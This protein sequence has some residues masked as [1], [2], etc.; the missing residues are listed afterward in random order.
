MRQ[1][2][3]HPS[4]QTQVPHFARK[5]IKVGANSGA[6]SATPWEPYQDSIDI[7]RWAPQCNASSLPG[8]AAL[9][10]VGS[11]SN[12]GSPV[13]R[14]SPCLLPFLQGKP[15]ACLN[16][17]AIPP[18]RSRGKPRP[19]CSGRPGSSPPGCWRR[20]C[21]APPTPEVVVTY[22]HN[23]FH[24]PTLHV[25]HSAGG[26]HASRTVGRAS[27]RRTLPV[28]VQGRTPLQP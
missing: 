24:N 21:R 23:A 6:Q 3:D 18:H 8:C 7:S 5:Y 19:P 10:R 16:L 9:L 1:G 27:I 12:I 14:A 26:Y 11:A 25:T 4:P 22:A 20:G 15:S 17:A 2:G 13:I 28:S